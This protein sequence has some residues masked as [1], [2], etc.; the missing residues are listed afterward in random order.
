MLLVR[1]RS[2]TVN[3]RCKGVLAQRERLGAHG[4][5]GARICARN[6]P[7]ATRR[8]ESDPWPSIRKLSE[9]LSCPNR[10]SISLVKE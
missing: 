1:L 6:R 10:W 8:F 2:R 9:V 7:D 3:P 4:P 5:R